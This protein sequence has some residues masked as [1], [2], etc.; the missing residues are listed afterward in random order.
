MLII[1]A[2]LKKSDIALKMQ[3]KH[4]YDEKVNILKKY[5]LYTPKEIAKI[6]DI[7]LKTVLSSMS[8]PLLPDSEVHFFW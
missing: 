6:T 5:N 2:A 7:P 3:K 1:K 4:D 8:F